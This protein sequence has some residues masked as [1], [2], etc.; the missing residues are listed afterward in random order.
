MEANGATKNV[1]RQIVHRSD[2]H[3]FR[4]VAKKVLIAAILAM[5]VSFPVAGAVSGA[6][7]TRSFG[8]IT[9]RIGRYPVAVYSISHLP[10][11]GDSLSDKPGKHQRNRLRDSLARRRRYCEAFGIA[12][13]SSLPLLLV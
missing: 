1:F 13:H 6:D 2:R 9:A 11:I 3:S 5:I 12:K 7:G 4:V 10:H 8:A